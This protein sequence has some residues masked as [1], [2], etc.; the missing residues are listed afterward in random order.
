MAAAVIT[1]LPLI[2][3]YLLAQRRFVDG[4]TMSGVK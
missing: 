1:V 3:A 4:L 2:I